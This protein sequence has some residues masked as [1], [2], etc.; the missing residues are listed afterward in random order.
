MFLYVEKT[1]EF[2]EVHY[3]HQSKFSLSYLSILISIDIYLF[4][5]KYI[6]SHSI[7]ILIKVYFHRND[8]LFL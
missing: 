3:K 6:N 5:Q 4:I 8:T 7:I 2:I 1:E